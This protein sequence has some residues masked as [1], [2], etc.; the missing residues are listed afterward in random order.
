MNGM[1]LT[2]E[3][4]AFKEDIA[5]K[6]V[7]ASTRRIAAMLHKQLIA[8]IARRTGK[9]IRNLSVRAK[10]VRSRGVV[11]AK[12]IVNTVGKKDNPKNAF[13]WR[14]VEFDHLTRPRKLS[15]GKYD[16]SR[17]RVVKGQGVIEQTFNNMQPK[18]QAMFYADLEKAINRR[19]A[20]G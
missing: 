11:V 1:Q 16:V 3:L 6:T 8:V 2:A 20:R 4:R 9:L 12:V 5:V 14:F 17:Q 18:I 7:R 15:K 10:Y 19:K 13:Y